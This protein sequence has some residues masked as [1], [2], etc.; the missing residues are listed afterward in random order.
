MTTGTGKTIVGIK[1]IKALPKAHKILWLTQTDELIYQTHADL[2]RFFG[3]ENVGL[4]RRAR[5]DVEHKIVVASLQTLQNAVYL[6]ALDPK[7]SFD[8][9]IVDEAHHARARTWERVVTYFQC[10]K[11][12]LTATPARMD[13][14]DLQDLFGSSAFELS[15]EE[16][17]EYR[18]IAEEE[19]RLILTNSKI[20]GVRVKG[21]EYSPEDLDRLVVSDDRNEIIVEAYKKYGHALMRKRS[22]RFKTI[23]FCITVAHAVRMKNLFLKH[24]MKAD[25]LV[26]KTGKKSAYFATEYRPQTEVERRDVYQAFLGSKGPEILC[27]VNVLNEGKNIPDVGC[28]LMCRPT[29]SKTIFAQQLGR[30]CRRIE[31]KKEHFCVLDFVDQVNRKHLPITLARITG[32]PYRPEEIVIEYYRGHDPLVVDQY[33][34]Y[35]SRGPEEKDRSIEG[36]TKDR[37]SS[38]LKHW[39]YYHKRILERDLRKENKLPSK[40]AIRRHWNSVE[41]CFQ[42]LGL[43]SLEV[44]T[45]AEAEGALRAYFTAHG[46][47]GVQDLTTKKKLPSI[48]LVKKFW[49]SWKGAQEILG[50]KQKSL[51]QKPIRTTKDPEKRAGLYT[52]VWAFKGKFKAE[53]YFKGARYYLGIFDTAEKAFQA[54]IKRREE[55]EKKS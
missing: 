38:R 54:R 55:L 27:V 8:L 33:V 18:L 51:K 52:G 45:K 48:K 28:L 40:A 32:K 44:W 15:Y 31:G 5:Q 3:E 47:I 25:I 37:I 49:G 1:I 7:K 12:G 11:L 10:P 23:C 16:A 26:G 6:E 36:W 53:L 2:T 42:E 29:M 41:E 50:F 13:G 22:L 24:G 30:G 4:F 39:V 34:N 21:E 46:K 20:E 9:M 43:P 35:L 17:K 19:Y 14:K